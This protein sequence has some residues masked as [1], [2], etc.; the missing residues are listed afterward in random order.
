M[1]ATW[2]ALRHA[3]ASWAEVFNDE[4]TTAAEATAAAFRRADPKGS[5][6]PGLRDALFGILTRFDKKLEGRALGYALRRLKGRI[7]SGCY[8][9][10]AGEERGGTTWIVRR[11]GDGG[12]E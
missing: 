5:D 4:P 6:D 11:C 7:A 2:R 3:L 9:D 12:D 1:T 10:K 8:F